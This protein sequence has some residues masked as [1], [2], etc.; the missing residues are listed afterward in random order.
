[1]MFSFSLAGVACFLLAC[2]LCSNQA[3]ENLLLY[4]TDADIKIFS[5][6]R[7]ADSPADS[8]EEEAQEY[9]HHKLSGNIDIAKEVGRQLGLLAAS[10]QLPEE[11]SQSAV[12]LQSR[13][14]LLHAAQ[15][16]LKNNSPSDIIATAAIQSLMDTAS[17]KA[18]EAYENYMGLDS[19]TLYRLAADEDNSFQS[20]GQLFAQLCGQ[21]ENETLSQLGC[22]LYQHFTADCLHIVQGV[23]YCR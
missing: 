13:V 18:P 6:S 15:S 3:K 5:S 1:M 16:C 9:V 20:V 10:Y 4:A 19:S 2:Q 22:N 17:K 14:L 23:T 21:K 7:A 11:T 12:A 8:G